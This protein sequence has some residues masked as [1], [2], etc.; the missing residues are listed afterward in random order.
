MSDSSAQDV[1][2]FLDFASHRGLMKKSSVQPIKTAC[3]NIFAV[4]DESEYADVSTLDMEA[5]IQRYQNINS[6]KVRP[7]TMHTYG[8]RVKYAVAEF[9]R[10]K[11]NPANWKPSGTQR[12]STSAQTSASRKVSQKE[13]PSSGNATENFGKEGWDAFRHYPSVSD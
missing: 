8:Q 9:L 12:S 4:L 5:V 13:P 10:Y 3:N 7:E 1:M 11:E 2:N 6:L